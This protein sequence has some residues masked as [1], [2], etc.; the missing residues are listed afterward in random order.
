DARSGEWLIYTCRENGDYAG[1]PRVV[2]YHADGSIAWKAVYSEAF[3][4]GIAESHMHFGWISTVKPDYRRIAYAYRRQERLG[5]ADGFCFDAVSGERIDYPFAYPLERMRPIDLDG[6]GYHEYLY[7]QEGYPNVKVIGGDGRDICA[8]GGVLVQIGKWYD[9]PGEQFMAYYPIE[10]K[11]RIWGDRQAAEGA[12]FRARHANGF[13][14]FMNK[15]T[16]SG[17]N[18]LVSIDCAM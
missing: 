4:E 17:Y 3:G 8:T 15:L 12:V 13:H 14:Q 7:W 16:G 10:R 6:D 11:V 1:C 5:R 18:W 9:W 2:T